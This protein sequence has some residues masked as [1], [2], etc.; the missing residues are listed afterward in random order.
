M[1]TDYLISTDD[2]KDILQDIEN[3]LNERF[4]NQFLFEYNYC[5][6]CIVLYENDE[7][8]MRTSSF[9]IYEEIRYKL[10]PILD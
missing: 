5:N 7:E 8:I 6:K 1:H 10:S 9:T 2:L 4:S 3:T